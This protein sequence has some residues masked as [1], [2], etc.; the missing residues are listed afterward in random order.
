MTPLEALNRVVY[1]M[2][3]SLAEPNKVNAFRNAAN[4][5]AE[6]PEGPRAV[7]AREA[8]DAE[9]DRLWAAFADYPGWGDGL[10]ISVGTD[11]QIDALLAALGELLG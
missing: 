6:L 4:V 9:R 10:R 11:P 7:H 8:T 5:V 1:L 2:D 3:R